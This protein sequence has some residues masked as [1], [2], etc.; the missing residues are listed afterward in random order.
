MPTFHIIQ[1]LY[2]MQVSL[3]TYRISNPENE[4]SDA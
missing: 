3:K 2:V 1:F 4:N